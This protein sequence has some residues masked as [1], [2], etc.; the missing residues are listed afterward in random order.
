LN[1]EAFDGYNSYFDA[2]K[3]YKILEKKGKDGVITMFNNY[4]LMKKSPLTDNSMVEKCTV[5]WRETWGYRM[6]PTEERTLNL[7]IKDDLKSFYRSSKT[8]PSL[9]N[10]S[11]DN[12]FNVHDYKYV[13]NAFYHYTSLGTITSD[14][15]SLLIKFNNGKKVLQLNLDHLTNPDFKA[16][17]YYVG[18]SLWIKKFKQFGVGF[19]RYDKADE[20]DRE[21]D[22][23]KDFLT[24][25]TELNAL[26]HDEFF[27][28]RRKVDFV[29]NNDSKPFSLMMDFGNDTNFFFNTYNLFDRSYPNLTKE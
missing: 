1:Y 16:S 23:T 26:D 27:V 19:V 14:G 4:G 25:N 2:L 7:A 20:Y 15:K 21:Q 12:D 8:K 13:S 24:K 17:D 9:D 10:S 22:N 11:G 6:N 18:E 28:K 3:M 29:E 5:F